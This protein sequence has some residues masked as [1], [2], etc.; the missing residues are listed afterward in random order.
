MKRLSKI[1]FSIFSCVVYVHAQ[2]DLV[3]FS[4]DRPLQLYAFLE[5]AERYLRGLET[6]TVI[7]RSSDN[8]FQRGYDEVKSLFPE[9]K[10]VQQAG[11]HV[12]VNFK[13]LTLKAVYD[14]QGEYV[15]FAVD[16]IVVTDY[17]DLND[18]IQALKKYNAY[19]FYLRMGKNVTH[20]YSH[21]CAMRQP[22]FIAQEDGI[23][24]WRVKDGHLAWKYPNTVDMALYKKSD[25][26]YELFALK[27]T[28]PN[29]FEGAWSRQIPKFLDKI[30]LCYERSK[31]VNLPL[32]RVQTTYNNRH[33]NAFSS[34]ELLDI[35]NSGKKIDINPLYQMRNAWTHQEYIPTFIER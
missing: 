33:M 13:P 1:L 15:L 9:V 11:S 21:N 8:A 5:S 3:V 22:P 19:G 35:F 10:F 12:N 18:C 31:I 20:N 24:A 2:T 32:N 30:V 7:Y 27:Y 23:C 16:D 6:T 14:S 25:I 26:Y 28:N 34:K 4:Y 17:V 29:T